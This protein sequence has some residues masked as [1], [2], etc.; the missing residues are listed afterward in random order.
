MLKIIAACLFITLLHS[1][2]FADHRRHGGYY[3]NQEYQNQGHYAY[4][5]RPVNYWR[6]VYN[7]R[8]PNDDRRY[9]RQRFR[10]YMKPNCRLGK[11]WDS[12]C[13]YNY[14][15]NSYNGYN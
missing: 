9:N 11:R 7:N 10:H 5:P 8:C 3:Q 4:R 1:K 13:D 15:N 2:A 12:R 6:P 14:Y